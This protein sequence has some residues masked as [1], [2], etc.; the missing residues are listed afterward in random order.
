MDPLQSLETVYGRANDLARQVD[1]GQMG[2]PVPSC[3]AWDVK[4]LV[5][6]LVGVVASFTNVARRAAPDTPLPPRDPGEAPAAA[7]ARVTEENLAAW[8]APGALDGE[9]KFAIGDI[10]AETAVRFALQ[11]TLVHAW[12]LSRATG[13]PVEVPDEIAAD[14]LAFARQMILPE[15]RGS[16]GPI[17]FEVLVPDSRSAIDQLVGFLGRQP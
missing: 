10:P 16:S 5:D 3:P 13:R 6:H 8:H 17:G 12:D 4:Q 2:D 9:V 14:A 15:Y 1:A 7:L 11:E